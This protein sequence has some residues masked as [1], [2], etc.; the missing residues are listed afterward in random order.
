MSGERKTALVVD[1]S[2]TVRIYHSS[3]LRNFGYEVDTAEN[4]LEALE[5][6]MKKKYDLILSDI[7]MPVMDGY[8]FVRKLRKLEEYRYTPVVFITTLNSEEDRRKALM[9]GG[10]LYIVKP[11]NLEV[12]EKILRSIS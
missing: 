3:L 6:A 8:E 12:L 1:D 7:N 11:I 2:L 10:T 4:G 5:M 9:A